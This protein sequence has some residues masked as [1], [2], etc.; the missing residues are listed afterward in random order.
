MNKEDRKQIADK[1]GKYFVTDELRENVNSALSTELES[2]LSCIISDRQINERTA[3]AYF[4]T[5]SLSVFFMIV[6][7]FYPTSGATDEIS[8]VDYIGRTLCGLFMLVSVRLWFK[9]ISFS[10]YLV[11]YRYIFLTLFVIYSIL[12]IFFIGSGVARIIL[13]ISGTN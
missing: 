9:F 7:F 5:Y 4:I 12:N 1:S 3:R 10:R 11:K 13:L 8:A 6:A 2:G